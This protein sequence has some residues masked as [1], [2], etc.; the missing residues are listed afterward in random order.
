MDGISFVVYI[1]GLIRPCR[2]Y[3]RSYTTYVVY[4]SS[5]LSTPPP[6]LPIYYSTITNLILTRDEAGKSK[7]YAF[8][9]FSNRE[10]AQQVMLQLSGVPLAE[11]PI[12]VGPV[13]DH[14]STGAA[15]VKPATT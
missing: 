4:S 8:A 3:I 6:L 14:G 12:K 15:P 2:I 1:Y 10:E 11:R 13:N 7:G 9:T 5:L